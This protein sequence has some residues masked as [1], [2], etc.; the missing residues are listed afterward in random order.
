[1]IKKITCLLLCLGIL[2]S[3]SSYDNMSFE[4]WIQKELVDDFSKQDDDSLESIDEVLGY[5]S[6]SKMRIGLSL[7]NEKTGTKFYI[8]QASFMT[9]VLMIQSNI[10]VI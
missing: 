4:E 9:L 6:F 5:M 1:M 8:Y 10:L 3:C 7:I 2:V